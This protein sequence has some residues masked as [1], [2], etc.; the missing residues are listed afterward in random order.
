MQEY[1]INQQ[2]SNLIK[3]RRSIFPNQFNGEEI[4]K[5]III[6][7]L[8]NANTAPS[9]KLTQPWFFKVFSKS[10]KI[11]LAQEL[12]RQNKLLPQNP[13]ENKLLQKFQNSSH[14]ICI[15]MRRD[16]TKSIPEWEEIAATAMAVQNIWLSCV[17]SNI[18]GYWSTPK[19]IEKLNKFLNLKKNE[20]CLGFF[21]IGIYESIKERKIPRKNIEQDTDWFD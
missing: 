18:G 11:H 14:I 2:I 1:M 3:K 17:D 8:K 5:Q 12:I 13:K 9:H 4:E 16:K 21:Y 7:L 6:E 10:S 20:R 15:C 19:G